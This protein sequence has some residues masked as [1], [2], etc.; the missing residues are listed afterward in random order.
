M[1]LYDPDLTIASSVGDL[2]AAPALVAAAA[3]TEYGDGGSTGDS[4]SGGTGASSKASLSF[5]L[6]GFAGFMAVGGVTLA[7]ETLP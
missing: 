5:P 3:T 7:S 6:Y 4:E 1:L 2:P